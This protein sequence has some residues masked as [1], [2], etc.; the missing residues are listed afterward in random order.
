MPKRNYQ[1]FNKKFHKFDISD[2]MPECED[3][4]PSEIKDLIEMFKN[5]LDDQQAGIDLMKRYIK[6][7]NRKIG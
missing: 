1:R 2:E 5:I 3:I 7:I 6:I 4:E